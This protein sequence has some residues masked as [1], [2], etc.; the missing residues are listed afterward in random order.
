[1]VLEDAVVSDMAGK[2]RAKSNA[3]ISSSGF[4]GNFKRRLEL[5]RERDKCISLSDH[6]LYQLVQIA[7]RAPRL[8]LGFSCSERLEGCCQSGT[9]GGLH[10]RRLA[11]KCVQ[12]LKII[13]AASTFPIAAASASAEKA[14]PGLA[15]RCATA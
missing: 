13:S 11:A 8:C 7:A 5:E 10:P 1:M 6:C 2:A 4:I 9:G 15:A 3:P 12:I 14:V